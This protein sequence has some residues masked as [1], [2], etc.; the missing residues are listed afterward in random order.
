MTSP[1]EHSSAGRGRPV[2]V[3]R[4]IEEHE[5]DSLGA[6]LEQLWTADENR[7]SLRELATYFN[8]QLLKRVLE[9]ADVRTLDGEVENIYRL[10][11]NDSSPDRVRIRRQLERDGID[12]DGLLSDFVTYQAIRT[13]LKKY[14]NVEYSPK[15]VDPIEREMSNIQKI[16]G[17]ADSVTE[18]KIE[19]LRKSGQL[20]IGNFRTLVDIRVVCED[21]DTQFDVIDL[22]ER[23]ECNCK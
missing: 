20:D 10:L 16:R 19:Q 17:R 18:G 14:R 22:L 7:Q 23:T 9:E 15:E 4:L 2:K 5:M 11:T 13:Y 8:Q 6:E 12:V 1:D 21:C 3:A